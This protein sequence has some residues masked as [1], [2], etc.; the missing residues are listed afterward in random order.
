M[1]PGGPQQLHGM[2][3]RKQT[4]YLS[5]LYYTQTIIILGVK[6]IKM[7]VLPSETVRFFFMLVNIVH[8]LF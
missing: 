2:R 5:S 6:P 3:Q 8:I 4:L 1:S 7:F